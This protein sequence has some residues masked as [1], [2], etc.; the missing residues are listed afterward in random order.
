MK[1]KLSVLFILML[2]LGVL[3]AQNDTVKIVIL[4]T[5]DMHAKIDN[6]PKIAYLVDSVR[7]N[8]ENVFLFSAGDCVT[9]NPIVDKY[10][11][12]GYPMFDLMNKLHYD[13]SAIGNHEFDLKQSGLNKAFEQADFPFVCANFDAK[14]A[15]LN[16]PNAFYMLKT[17]E[18]IKIGVLGLIQLDKNGLPASNPKNLNGIN[19][20]DPFK[21]AKKYEKY[22]DSVDIYIALTHLGIDGD[23]KLAKKLDFF[24][25]IIGGHTHTVLPNGEKV[26]GTLIVQAGSYLNYLGILTIKIFNKKLVDISDTLINIK[27]VVKQDEQIAKIVNDYNNNPFFDEVIGQ[28]QDSIV[29]KDE[30]GAM[31]TDA[32]RDTLHC[33]IAFQN[34]GGIRIHEIP[35]G[36][37]TRKKILELSP[38]GNTFVVYSLKPKQIKKLITYA[39]NLEGKNEIQPS[40]LQIVLNTDKNNNLKSV[41]LFDE[42]GKSLENKEYTVAI[43]DYM[44]AAY[45]LKFLKNPQKKTGIVDAEA[46]MNFIRKN[47]P[48]NYKG[49][50]RVKINKL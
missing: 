12:P 47:S 29:G 8:N 22:K 25:I 31:M 2:F 11:V 44:A 16:Q 3:V 28:A 49:A 4:H 48:I 42:N 32:M 45:Q 15:V 30:L 26:K 6:F 19:F 27:N 50:K 23:E 34:I 14:N 20:F 33:D 13:I 43:N 9:G 5:N 41:E 37:I 38:F 18:G 40:G 21:T 36:N 35:T 1:K 7:K 17:N 39:Y 46:T 10:K 24:D